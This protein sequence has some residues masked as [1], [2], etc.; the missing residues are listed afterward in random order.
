MSAAA[1]LA[2][3]EAAGVRLRLRPDGRV[4]VEADAPPPPALLAELRQYRDE[5]AALLAEREGRPAREATQTAAPAPD[6][7]EVGA[8]AR[9]LLRFASETAG[10]ALAPP[11]PT[12]AE[13]LA[14]ELAA[15]AE[16]VAEVLRTAPPDEDAEAMVEYY[17]AEASVRPYA[18]ED[19][20]PLRDGL[21]AGRARERVPSGRVRMR[22]A[23]ARRLSGGK[24]EKRSYRSETAH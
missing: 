20:D 1:T 7:V 21:W 3:A 13:A 18:P 12:E 10:E 16:T 11:D 9:E 23:E 22:A 2:R 19:P 17:A 24:P 4:R 14:R 6:P 15:A 5:V 8:Q